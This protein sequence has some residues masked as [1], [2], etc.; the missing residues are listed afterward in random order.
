MD[1][2]VVPV[3]DFYSALISDAEWDQMTVEERW[4]KI[5]DWEMLRLEALV[6]LLAGRPARWHPFDSDAGPDSQGKHGIKTGATQVEPAPVIILDGAY[7]SGPQLADLVCL[8]ILIEA[9]NEQRRARLA[10]RE[11]AEFL[12][13]WHARWDAVEDF[14][15]SS[16]RPRKSFDVIVTT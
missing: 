10:K 3:D 15:F 7:S 11:E 8:S 4:S 1:A 12:A 2:V 9:P 13:Q 6:P 16:V 5:F 14:Y